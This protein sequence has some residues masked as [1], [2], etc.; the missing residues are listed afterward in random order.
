MRHKKI[1]LF[2]LDGTLYL[3]GRVLP[4]AV[5]LVHW[6]RKQGHGVFFF[7]NN[8]SRSLNDYV[9][10]LKGM[11]FGA[12]PSEIVMSTHTL[13]SFLHKKRWKNIFLL[14]TPSMESMLKRSG[15]RHRKSDRPQA[16]VVGFD[17]TITY[18]KLLSAARWIDQGVPFVVTHP[19]YFCPTEKGPEPDCGAMAKLLEFTT[20]KM[21]LITLGK[22]HR[23]MIE[24]VFRRLNR[25][26]SKNE[27]L[28]IGDRL[29]TDIQMA[30]NAGID[31]LLVL[32]GETKRGGLDKRMRSA[33]LR[34]RWILPSVKA[35][36]EVLRNN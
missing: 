17:K 1:F 8:S 26:I 18:E 10:K 19:D 7:T 20:G 35:L 6:L 23:S 12:R 16:V 24:E 3:G 22:P 2:D 15:I 21:P 27:F 14:G 25:K 30:R 32:T 13:I 33:K 29:Q 31:S 9:H 4:G 36:L 5:E 28:L 11:K 34:P